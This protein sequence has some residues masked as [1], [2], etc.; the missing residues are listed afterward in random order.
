MMTE[1]YWRMSS[2]KKELSSEFKMT[3]MIYF[4]FVSSSRQMGLNLIVPGGTK[5]IDATGKLI[6]PGRSMHIEFRIDILFICFL[7]D[8]ILFTMQ[9]RWDR[10]EY[11]SG[12]IHHGNTNKR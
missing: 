2:L 7:F 1:L 11:S 9:I 12:I 10:Y 4:S 3:L 6:L 5:T 8:L